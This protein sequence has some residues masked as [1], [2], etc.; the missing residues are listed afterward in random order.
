VWWCISVIPALRRLK[1]G[2]SWEFKANWGYID[3]LCVK[4]MVFIMTFS[5]KYI[6]HFVHLLL[7]F[8]P[9][10]TGP[11]LFPKSLLFY[12][13]LCMYTHTHTHTH[14][15]ICTYIAHMRENMFLFS[16][17][18][19]KISL[20]SPKWTWTQDPPTSVSWVLELLCLAVK[21]L[22]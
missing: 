16:F 11:F 10:S 4:K 14:T 20:C 2:G 17:L 21:D 9:P 3:R 6:I 19:D 13:L 15:H 8:L 12:F 5:C 1:A 7:P 18:W 22:K